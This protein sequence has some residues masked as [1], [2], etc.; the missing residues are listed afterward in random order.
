[1]RQDVVVEM[2][3]NEVCR[4]APLRPRPPPSFSTGA[5]AKVSAVHGITR[6]TAMS[7][8]PSQPLY[9]AL[10]ALLPRFPDTD[11]LIAMV[12]GAANRPR[13]P[14][15]DRRA[16]C[17]RGRASWCVCRSTKRPKRPRAILP[18]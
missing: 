10:Q 2:L 5:V 17:M 18:I 7:P 3:N 13:R 14:V 4:R 1:M 12:S 8:R 15:R 16:D 9:M 6:C 11:H